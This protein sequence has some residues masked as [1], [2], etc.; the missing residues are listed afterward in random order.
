[1][2]I[3]LPTMITARLALASLLVTSACVAASAHARPGP[4]PDNGGITLPKGFAASV[5]ADGLDAVRGLAVSD[6]GIVYAR[7]EDRGVV[8]VRAV[9][10]GG[11]AGG[12]KALA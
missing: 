10:G 4:A 5:V 3:P 9:A 11:R 7:V 2:S 6:D 12:G 1:M 8:A